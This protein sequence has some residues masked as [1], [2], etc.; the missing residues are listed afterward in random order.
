MSMFKKVMASV[1]I[2]S[3]TVDTRLEDARAV[4]GGKLHGVVAIR[5]GQ[6]EQQ[7]DAIYLYLN[8][9]Y[10]KEENDRK[11]KREAEI[12]R[13]EVTKGILLKAGE[14]REIPF[15]ITL[16]ERTP[17]SYRSTPVWLK[18]GLD[19]K[20][21]LDP[22]DQDY[23]EILP[24]DNM[25]TVLGALDELGFRLREVTNEHAPRLGKGLPFVQE[26]EYVP[27]REF[28][29][30]LDE[31]EVMFF[32]QGDDLELVMQVDRKAR[33]LRGAFA[34]AMGTDE[35]LIRVNLTGNELRRG[36]DVVSRQLHSIISRYI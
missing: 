14:V 5:G 34:E 3:A 21:A 11:V 6:V 27:T 22:G 30:A 9:Q 7:I 8:T 36:V 35:S 16:P 17:V 26:F 28:R 13:F 4:A 25:N 12:T 15:T 32:P 20:M 2:G 18:T 23:L 31:L 10:E 1:G 24:N 29:G 33:G 19:I